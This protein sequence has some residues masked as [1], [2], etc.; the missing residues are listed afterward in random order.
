MTKIRTGFELSANWF[1]SP[2]KRRCRTSSTMISF[3]SKGAFRAEVH[4][5]DP[6][7]PAGV[8]ADGDDQTLLSA[9]FSVARV[10]AQADVSTRSEPPRKMAYHAAMVSAGT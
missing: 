7:V 9:C 4:G 1:C 6:A 3:S 5:A 2:R 8:A 10:I